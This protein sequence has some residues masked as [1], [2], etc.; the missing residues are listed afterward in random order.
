MLPFVWVRKKSA[1]YRGEKTYDIVQIEAPELSA[2]C[3]PPIW[4]SYL[5][6]W[7]WIADVGAADAC[8]LIDLFRFHRNASH[9][10]SQAEQGKVQAGIAILNFSSDP[11]VPVAK[12]R[13]C[14]MLPELRE[15]PVSKHRQSPGVH[16]D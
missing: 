15:G 12:L 2:G 7:L 13:K 5:W 4:V 14:A 8:V 16:D 10:G 9:D 3:Y 11:P 1:G 6:R